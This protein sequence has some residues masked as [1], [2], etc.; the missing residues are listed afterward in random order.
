MRTQEN[1]ETVGNYFV[2]PRVSMVGEQYL[3]ILP[4]AQTGNSLCS[5][6]EAFLTARSLP[7]WWEKKRGTGNKEKE[8]KKNK[9]E[10]TKKKNKK[11]KKTR[12]QTVSTT[13]PTDQSQR[14]IDLL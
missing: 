8:E 3:M 4:R 1:N 13:R 12:I 10:E 9:K 14:E 6:I 7:L 11:K 5:S 2:A